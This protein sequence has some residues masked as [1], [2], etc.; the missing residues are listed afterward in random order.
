MAGIDTGGQPAGNANDVH[1]DSY[2]PAQTPASS[3]DQ[4]TVVIRYIAQ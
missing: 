3:V 4:H 2:S 1:G